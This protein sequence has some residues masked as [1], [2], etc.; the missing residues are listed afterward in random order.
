[1]LGRVGLE[2]LTGLIVTK[3]CHMGVSVLGNSC[4][5]QNKWL[6]RCVTEAF[7][8]TCAVYTE[9]M[10]VVW[11]LYLRGRALEAQTRSP[12]LQMLTNHLPLFDVFV[13]SLWLLGTR[14]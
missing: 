6:P 10:V 5:R 1:M 13:F 11:W 2:F 12:G 3:W 9:G 8:T 7:S 4:L 14:K